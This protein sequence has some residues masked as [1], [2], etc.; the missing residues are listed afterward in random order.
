MN[1]SRQG[2]C[3]GEL[4][5]FLLIVCWCFCVCACKCVSSDYTSR[6]WEYLPVWSP[7]VSL[8]GKPRVTNTHFR[9]E[10]IVS[11]LTWICA[12]PAFYSLSFLFCLPWATQRMQSGLGPCIH[13]AL[14]VFSMR[15][16][17]LFPEIL[18]LCLYKDKEISL[19]AEICCV[20]LISSDYS[21]W[22]LVF[23]RFGLRR[24]IQVRC[25]FPMSAGSN[26]LVKL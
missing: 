3:I 18:S 24:E 9:V 25:E 17:H 5:A 2:C 23:W 20:S 14:E 10:L 19:I 22:V 11:F 15:V 6:P 13:L 4:I 26:A 7:H 16:P 8:R 21:T 1:A 12:R